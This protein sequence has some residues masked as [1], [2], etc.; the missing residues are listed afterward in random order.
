MKTEY[1]KNGIVNI[2]AKG[3]K[4]KALEVRIP[5]WCDEFT[6][7]KDYEADKGYARFSVA[8]DEYNVSIDMNMTVKFYH[9][10]T[11]VRSCA[12]KTAVMYGPVLYCAEAVDNGDGLFN[13]TVLK[14][15][16]YDVKYSEE[17]CANVIEIDGEKRE[18]SASLYSDKDIAFVNPIRIKLI[19]YFAFANRGE[20]DMAVWLSD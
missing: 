19:P 3:M 8:S 17:Y 11:G 5:Y 6:A 20:S 1:P 9:A 13:L 4:G 12:G 10:H 7:D 2:T 18:Y 16:N 15:G 14:N